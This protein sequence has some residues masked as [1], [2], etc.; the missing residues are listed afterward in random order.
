MRNDVDFLVLSEL[1]D[2]KA[3][4]QPKADTWPSTGQ[5]KYTILPTLKVSQQ[6]LAVPFIGRGSCGARPLAAPFPIS[7]MPSPLGSEL[8]PLNPAQPRARSCLQVETTHIDTITCNAGE[9]ERA[10]GLAA[11][12]HVRSPSNKSPPTHRRQEDLH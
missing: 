11:S 10:G 2:G 9:I 12:Q 5:P 7:H 4:L 3:D 8:R 6:L 1:F